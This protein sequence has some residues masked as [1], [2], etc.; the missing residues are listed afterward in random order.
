MKKIPTE[1]QCF[2]IL[3]EYGTPEHVIAHCTGVCSVAVALGEQL[4]RVG[5]SIDIPLLR[6]S[7]LLHDI[8]RVHPAHEEVGAD[9]LESIGY[10]QVGAVTRLHT[11]YRQYSP[12][13]RIKEI[14]LLCIGDR[15]VLEDTYV[16]VDERMEYIKNK[17]IRLGR[18]HYIGGI[19][20]SKIILK[21]YIGQIED[22]IGI[23]LDDLMRGNYE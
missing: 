22:A 11:K 15:T 12:L 10:G 3:K 20:S 23:T 2:E 4:N 18:E 14:D 9:Y 13:S 1:Q 21:E 6:A 7:A 16:G 17:A 8:A 19:E 5:Y